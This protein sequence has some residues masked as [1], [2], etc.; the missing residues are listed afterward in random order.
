MYCDTYSTQGNFV[1]ACC[2]KELLGKNLK[3]G[4]YDVTIKE[5]FYKGKLTSEKKLAKLLKQ[6][7]N[8][9]LFGS[10]AVGVAL[11][12]GFLSERDIIKIAGVLHAIILKV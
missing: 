1:V 9:N 12:Q 11:K 7:N 6:A 8:I 10:K 3:E 4:N 5:S 2:D